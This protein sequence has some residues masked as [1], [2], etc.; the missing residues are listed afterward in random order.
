MDKVFN[1][2]LIAIYSRGVMKQAIK[3]IFLNKTGLLVIGIGAI[4]ICSNSVQATQ[5]QSLSQT[6]S[7]NKSLTQLS[8]DNRITSITKNEHCHQFTTRSSGTEFLSTK[9]CNQSIEDANLIK[10]DRPFNVVTQQEV[11][12]TKPNIGPASLKVIIDY[13]PVNVPITISKVDGCVVEYEINDENQD[14][15]QGDSGAPLV[16]SN[17]EV[18]AVHFALD[19]QYS[20]PV[21]NNPAI[22]KSK[23]GYA[24]YKKCID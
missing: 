18:I 3:S 1:N 8:Q 11:E 19:K 13:S 9:H 24:L 4:T 17:D 20:K 21:E 2:P 15:R 14:V 7:N 16:N 5:G 10:K 22:Q 23:K 12:F 6:T